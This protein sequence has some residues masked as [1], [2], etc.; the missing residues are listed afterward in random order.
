MSDLKTK[1]GEMKNAESTYERDM[2]KAID[3][4]QHKQSL[5]ERLKRVIGLDSNINASI[6]AA[7]ASRKKFEA[8]ESAHKQASALEES[9]EK[10]SKTDEILGEPADVVTKNILELFNKEPSL[11]KPYSSPG[12]RFA[13]YELTQ[14]DTMAEIAIKY[15]L[16]RMKE[17]GTK[18]IVKQGSFEKGSYRMPEGISNLAALLGEIQTEHMNAHGDGAKV[19]HGRSEILQSMFD[20]GLMHYQDG[21]PVVAENNAPRFGRS[22]KDA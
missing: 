16:K 19:E 17:A 10:L 22:V 13:S 21:Q 18:I 14:L 1:A 7:D 9:F 3:D 8:S 20:H 5:V 11:A 15:F 6:A 12:T 4:A 2:D